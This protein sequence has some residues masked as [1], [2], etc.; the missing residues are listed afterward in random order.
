MGGTQGWGMVSLFI[1]GRC[2]LVNRG[3]ELQDALDKVWGFVFFRLFH[4]EHSQD[5]KRHNGRNIGD[6]V[7]VQCGRGGSQEV[8]VP[9]AQLDRLCPSH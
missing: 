9:R 1:E 6:G 5:L 4:S 8:L 7:P 3:Q 2:K